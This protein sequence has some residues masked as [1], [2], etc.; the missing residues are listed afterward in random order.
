MDPYA[1]QRILSLN[2]Q[3]YQTFALQFSATR[4]R[5]QPG[6][7][8][9]LDSIPANASLLDLGC[10][11]GELRRQLIRL[12][13]CGA[14]TGL[15]FSPGLL[16]EAAGSQQSDPAARW[17][18]ADL[19]STDWNTALAGQIFDYVLAFAVLHHIPGSELRL[20]FLSKVRSVLG[21][22]G[23]LIFSVWQFQ[24]S[25][26]LLARVQPWEKIGLQADQVDPDDFLLD[27]RSGGQG[28]RYV[29]CY[30]QEELDHLARLSGF[31]CQ[32]AFL[33]DGENNC[34][35]LYHIWSPVP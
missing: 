8:R 32:A 27:W 7:R 24:N 19:T 12:N 16:H 25:P 14:Y 20:A 1:L 31:Q 2:Q 9:I 15:D 22:N 13:Y 6:V 34:L 5:I 29:H 30:S 35:G 26:R 28:L 4:Q 33:S 18:E 11:N 10:G 17:I 23:W 21:Q 3:F